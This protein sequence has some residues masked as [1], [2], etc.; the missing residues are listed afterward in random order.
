MQNTTDPQPMQWYEGKYGGIAEKIARHW[1]RRIGKAAPLF[2][3][4][5]LWST[6]PFPRIYAFI[7]HSTGLDALCTERTWSI[8]YG[9][10]A[11]FD[12]TGLLPEEIVPIMANKMEINCFAVLERLPLKSAIVLD[13]GSSYGYYALLLSRL[14]GNEG[15]VYSFEPDP[16]SIARLGRNLA[17]N[18]CRNVTSVSLCVSNLSG[19]LVYWQ[20]FENEPWRNK[21]ADGSATMESQGLTIVPV[22]TLDDFTRW[23][24]IPDKVRLV[25]IDVEGAELKVL[26]GATELITNAK[27]WILCELHGKGIALQVF[28]F[29]SEHRYCWEM[30]EY[31]DENRQHILAFPDEQA[32]AH[33]K[34]I[35]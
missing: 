34:M 35:R 2:A 22:T 13:V 30:V 25:K 6:F 9:P 11:G 27:P 24:G 7:A 29:L 17:I 18:G 1:L 16:N 14:V 4:L 23:A 19:R 33:R 12:L 3:K 20:R 28:S 31:V 26:E 15:C 32:G 8:H 10:L 21:I 5:C